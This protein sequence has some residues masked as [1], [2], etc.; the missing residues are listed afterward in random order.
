MMTTS[1]RKIF[2]ILLPLLIIVVAVLI[3]FGL[4]FSKP[5]AAPVMIE[6]KSWL[7]QTM[8]VQ[9]GTY[10]PSV[11]LYGRVDSLWTTRLTAAVEADVLAV[12]QVA[13]DAVR[14]G[15]VLVRLDAQDVQLRLDQANADLAGA[16]AQAQ[17]ENIRHKANQASLPREQRLLNLARSEER[18][19]KN[20]VAKKVTSQSSMDN[21]RQ[22]VQ[23]RAIALTSREQQIAEHDTRRAEIQARIARATAAVQQAILAVQRCQIIAPFNGVISQQS[24]SPGQRVRS[25]E[26]LLQLYDTDALVIRAQIPHRY[27]AGIRQALA[28]GTALPVRGTLDGQ[29]IKAQV[30]NL[31]GEVLAGSG[32]VEALLSVEG[33]QTRLLQ[34]RF[35]ALS[36]A[37]PAVD[38]VMAVPHEALYGTNRLYRLDTDSRL[39]PVTVERIGEMRMDAEQTRVLVRSSDLQPGMKI[40]VTQLP[41]AIAGLLVRP[42]EG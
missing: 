20:L 40:V 19:L 29:P 15:Q 34:G 22:Q 9:P 6:E 30:R 17:A 23:Q 21:V 39:H 16:K 41:Q 35:V 32:G 2:V 18:R 8:P 12:E 27:L 14:K 5:K 10:A 25:G 11:A 42:A 36:L 38:D 26:V 13:G 4:I 37:L 7:V 3:A 28:A 24:V 33:A 31:G 1:M